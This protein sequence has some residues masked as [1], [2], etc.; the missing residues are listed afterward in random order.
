M[1]VKVLTHSIRTSTSPASSFVRVV[2]LIGVGILGVG[3]SQSSLLL[4]LGLVR[5]MLEVALLVLPLCS[6]LAQRPLLSSFLL[7]RHHGLTADRF[8]VLPV[9][10]LTSEDPHHAVLEAPLLSS[11]HMPLA[12]SH[13]WF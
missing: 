9:L 3:E 11:F 8:R 1:I 5:A 10:V 6:P 7:L 4:S 12:E 2:S 13:F